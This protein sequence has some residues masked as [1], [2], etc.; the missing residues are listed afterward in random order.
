MG[1]W[2]ERWRFKVQ[3][4]PSGNAQEIAR[5]EAP[6][7]GRSSR[8]AALAAVLEIAD[9]ECDPKTEKIELNYDFPEVCGRQLLATKW[10][11]QNFTYFAALGQSFFVGSPLIFFRLFTYGIPTF[12]T[13]GIPTLRISKLFFYSKNLIFAKH[14]YFVIFFIISAN[15]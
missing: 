7:S 2:Q 1:S 13:F 10:Y 4:A 11:A 9:I 15:V 6:K 14:C 8:E 12:A 5:R 3:R